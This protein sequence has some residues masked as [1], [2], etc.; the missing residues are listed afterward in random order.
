[1]RLSVIVAVIPARMFVMV[2]T[3]PSDIPFA[4]MPAYDFSP[5]QVC[6]VGNVFACVAVKAS[7]FCVYSNISCVM[8][9]GKILSYT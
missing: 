6:N 2:D 4:A 1:M 5:E 3:R 9:G 7:R 8:M